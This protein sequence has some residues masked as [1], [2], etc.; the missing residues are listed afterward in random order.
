M[1]RKLFLALPLLSSPLLSPAQKNDF[2]FW[3]LAE[4]E[5]EMNKYLLG[6]FTWQSRFTDNA[7][8]FSYYYLD[9]GITFH[10]DKN[11]RFSADYILVEKKRTDETFSTRHQYN[12]FLT[13]R[14]KAGRFIFFD[15][16]LN[17]GQFQDY[18]SSLE[19]K[20]LKDFYLR[21]KFTCRY[22]LEKKIL[23]FLADEVYYRLDGGDPS[24]HT[25]TRNRFYAGCIY[26][27]NSIDQLE[28]FY[29]METNFGAPLPQNNYVVGVSFSHNFFQ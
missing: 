6:H 7:G 29:L 11:L 28:L 19:G 18:Y 17:E 26:N 23:P 16:V 15:R 1:L 9:G 27:I 13:Y 20:Y 3:Q 24:Y 2:Q 10:L 21:N 25:F 8:T 12:L 4:T 14:K 5:V 22:K